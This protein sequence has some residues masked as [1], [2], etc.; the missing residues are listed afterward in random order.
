MIGGFG[1]SGAVEEVCDEG[2]GRDGLV[3][4]EVGVGAWNHKNVLETET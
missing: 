3:G 2:F 1:T 4:L